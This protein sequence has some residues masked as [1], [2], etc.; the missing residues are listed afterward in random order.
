MLLM[1]QSLG[2][3]DDDCL[4]RCQNKYGYVGGRRANID[5]QSRYGYN[6]NCEC[7]CVLNPN[8]NISTYSACDSYCDDYSYCQFIA[9]LGCIRYVCLGIKSNRRRF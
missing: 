8:D 7:T 4:S 1:T 9:G 2:Q 3:H 5:D 6:K